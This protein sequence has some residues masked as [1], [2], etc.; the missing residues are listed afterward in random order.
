MRGPES[1]LVDKILAYLR[2]G[3]G[4][5]MKIHGGMY[6][7]GGLPD[8][9]GCRKS[10]FYGFEVKTEEAYKRPGHNLSGRQKLNLLKIREEG[11][12]AG[13]VSSIEQVGR[14]LR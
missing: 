1:R 11:G 12:V 13:V 5:W 6:Q 7:T 3:G 8:I 2:E 14:L 9:I 4:W 10:Q